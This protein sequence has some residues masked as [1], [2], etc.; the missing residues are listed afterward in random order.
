MCVCFAIHTMLVHYCHL[1]MVIASSR[2]AIPFRSFDHCLPSSTLATTLPSSISLHLI[3][4][5]FNCHFIFN[6]VS[7]LYFIL[8][9]CI[10]S[11]LV[12]QCSN[13]FS[14][15]S[16]LLYNYLL[17][18]II[19]FLLY[20]N[21]FL[22]LNFYMHDLYNISCINVSTSTTD[23]GYQCLLYMTIHP[24]SDIY[25]SRLV[26]NSPRRIY[27]YSSTNFHAWTHTTV[28]VEST[29]SYIIIMHVNFHTHVHVHINLDISVR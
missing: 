17:V 29:W 2:A 24:R 15:Y 14:S 26:W 16:Q 5:L 27:L 19:I 4:T 7:L 22:E 23:I 18:S 21:Y 28:I 1:A 6:I 11:Y 8:S 9:Y 13:V 10:I 25:A 3:C 12:C 20:V